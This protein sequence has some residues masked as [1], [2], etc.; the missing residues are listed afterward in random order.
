MSFPFLCMEWYDQAR[1]SHGSTTG[2]LPLSPRNSHR[3][4]AIEKRVR[5][6]A[7]TGFTYVGP[8]ATAQAQP[9]TK[10][11][12]RSRRKQRKDAAAR[13]RKEKRRTEEEEARATTRPSARAKGEA[14]QGKGD[15]ADAAPA[16]E[17]ARQQQRKEPGQEPRPGKVVPAKLKKRAVTEKTTPRRCATRQCRPSIALPLAADVAVALVAMATPLVAGTPGRAVVTSG[18]QYISCTYDSS[19]VTWTCTVSA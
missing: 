15:A 6:I 16:H 14:D 17:E 12:A 5:E 2:S 7:T 3:S 4:N 10:I 1:H 19:S 18:T 9:R 11:H 8:G 13:R